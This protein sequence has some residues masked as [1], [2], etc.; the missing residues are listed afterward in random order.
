VLYEMLTGRRAFQGDDPSDT[1]AAVLRAEVDWRALPAS[2][3]PHVR[4]VVQGCLIKDR[5]K[6]IPDISAIRFLMSAAEP[7]PASSESAIGLPSSK[8]RWLAAGALGIAVGAA[9]TA[10]VGLPLVRRP[11]PDT[12]PIRFIV[13]SPP[14]AAFGLGTGSPPMSLSPDGRRLVFVSAS[15]L[16]IRSLDSLEARVLPGARGVSGA[17]FWSADG[18]FIGFFADGELS[19]KVFRPPRPLPDR[20]PPSPLR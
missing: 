13:P 9:I 4:T 6:R 2:V 1:L 7:A 5:A 20:V 10:G 8:S 18:R 14:N 15:G 3:P 17:P 19:S 12:A 16:W 11:I